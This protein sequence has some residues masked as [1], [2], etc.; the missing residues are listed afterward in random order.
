MYKNFIFDLYGTLI[1]I[2]TDEYSLDFWRKV[3]SIFAKGRASY[4]PVELQRGYRRN[5]RRALWRERFRHPTYRH[6]DID[7]LEVFAALYADKGVTAGDELLR[8]TA[9]RFRKASTQ[10]LCLY[11]GV[12]DLLETLKKNGKKI[13]LLS[14]AQESFTIP[15][16]EEVGILGY[17]DGIMI[18]SE[19]RVCKPN[20]I[21]FERLI[22]RYELDPRECLMIGNDK[23]SDMLGAKGVGIDGLYIHQEISPPVDSEDEIEAKW[24]IMDGNVYRIKELV[25]ADE[26]DAKNGKN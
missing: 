18:S 21:F 8:D 16:L 23:N 11:D 1:D 12:L 15:E 17:F 22:R 7:L 19:E 6:R 3:V 24:K 10:K 13:Y 5:V 2:R 4:S 20:R 25:L 26:A 9:R 14:N